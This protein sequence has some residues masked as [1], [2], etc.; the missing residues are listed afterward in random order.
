MYYYYYYY[1][2]ITSI[3]TYKR[4]YKNYKEDKTLR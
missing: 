1:Y 3:S 2:L 4:G